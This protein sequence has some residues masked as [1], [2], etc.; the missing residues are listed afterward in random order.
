MAMRVLG[1][2][3]RIDMRLTK[4]EITIARIA[5]D[6]FPMTGARFPVRHGMTR[7]KSVGKKKCAAR[8]VKKNT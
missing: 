4:S 3:A 5:G 1:V 6:R 2:L 8:Y 7:L